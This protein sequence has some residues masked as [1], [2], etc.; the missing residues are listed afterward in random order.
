MCPATD[1]APSALIDMLKSP[2]VRLLDLSYLDD[3]SGTTLL[4][5]AA[6]RKDLR[7]VELAIQA[8]ADV[9][10]R[11][12]RG[13]TVG[14]GAGKDDR[15]KV[16]LRQC[17]L[18]YSLCKGPPTNRYAVTNQDNALLED[19]STPPAMKG[20]LSKYTN[21]AKGYNPRWFVLKD[22]V[23]SCMYHPIESD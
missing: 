22:G 8:G 20:F 3:G 9:F 14:E 13:K 15:V 18:Q 4:H 1:P 6:K 16:F 2:R 17:K 23:L 10:A 12:R 5:E 7:L 19:S 21:V 11:D